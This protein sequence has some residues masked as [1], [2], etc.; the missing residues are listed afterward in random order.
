MET[1]GNAKDYFNIFG[2]MSNRPSENHVTHAV[3]TTLHK[4]PVLTQQLL[5]HLTEIKSTN[6]RILKQS[7]YKKA[8]FDLV[9]TDCEE[10]YVVF[11]FKIDS[12]IGKK[13]EEQDQL[14]RYLSILQ[15]RTEEQRLFFFVSMGSPPSKSNEKVRFN[16]ISWIELLLFLKSHKGDNEIG[17]FVLTDLINFLEGSKIDR[18]LTGGRRMWKCDLCELQTNGYDIQNHKRKHVRE[19]SEQFDEHY[20]KKRQEFEKIIE[21]YIPAING[22]KK[23]IESLQKIE[24]KNFNVVESLISALNAKLPKSMW[25]YLI[26]QIK[27]SFSNMAF[28]KLNDIII[29]QLHEEEILILVEPRYESATYEKILQLKQLIQRL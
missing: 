7:K 25:I 18:N 8:I 1:T 12:P 6:I 4:N 20:D 10:F 19:Y 22:I 29:N 23:E 17:Q 26:S 27:S 9:L 24:M 28:K 21:Q 3:A 5:F 16:T 15:D 11:E 14:D 13:I 2:A